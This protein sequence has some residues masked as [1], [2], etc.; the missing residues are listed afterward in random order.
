[1]DFLWMFKWFVDCFIGFF[2]KLRSQ[3]KQWFDDVN[4]PCR[5]R[6]FS[7][8]QHRFFL[9]D[10]EVNLVSSTWTRWAYDCLT[11]DMKVF[12]IYV[13]FMKIQVWYKGTCNPSHWFLPM[14]GV[15]VRSCH[16]LH[17]TMDYQRQWVEAF[18]VSKHIQCSPFGNFTRSVEQTHP[19]IA[20]DLSFSTRVF[21]SS[22]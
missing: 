20:D 2:A 11:H 15:S 5:W 6:A 10:I 8:S 19:S 13:W 3:F 7:W 9:H 22:T 1:M 18:V 4:P 14:D 16:D 12:M 21:F 17:Q